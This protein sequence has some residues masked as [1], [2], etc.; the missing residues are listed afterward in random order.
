MYVG[1]W[2]SVVALVVSPPDSSP[3][4]QDAQACGRHGT[5]RIPPRVSYY[6]D[7]HL[8]GKMGAAACSEVIA[9]SSR[10]AVSPRLRV[11]DRSRV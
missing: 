9:H 4:P 6:L 11:V 3:R 8:D 1:E 7:L 2:G 5:S 10:S